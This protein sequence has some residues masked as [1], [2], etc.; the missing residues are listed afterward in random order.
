MRLGG[1]GAISGLILVGCPDGGA[2]ADPGD[3][4][5]TLRLDA[6]QLAEV[7]VPRTAYRVWPVEEVM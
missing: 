2:P 1:L 6:R 3:A 4:T 7:G 5:V